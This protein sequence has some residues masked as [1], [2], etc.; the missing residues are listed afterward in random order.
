MDVTCKIIP[1]YKITIRN[2][3]EKNND[4]RDVIVAD[5]IAGLIEGIV[6]IEVNR[7]VNLDGEP[8]G[9]DFY[10][11]D[12]LLMPCETARRRG[13]HL[14]DIDDVDCASFSAWV[15]S[16]AYACYFKDPKNPQPVC[17]E[18][19]HDGFVSSDD[20]MKSCR[21]EEALMRAIYDL[22]KDHPYRAA[23]LKELRG[24]ESE[25]YKR[26]LEDLRKKLE[27]DA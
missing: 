3:D 18:V 11:T 6:D 23:R 9:M 20:I 19:S 12:F 25:Y 17:D 14:F 27:R 1:L 16:G 13:F 10:V 24:R 22:T 7:E 21:E 2:Y 5:H 15:D 8:Y 4:Y 26:A